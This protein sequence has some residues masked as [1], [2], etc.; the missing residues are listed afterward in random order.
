LPPV[1]FGALQKLFKWLA[2]FRF[3]RGVFWGAAPPKNCLKDPAELI[4]PVN[5]DSNMWRR[6]LYAA[7]ASDM[8]RRIQYA[9][10]AYGMR[11]PHPVC[12][13]AYGMR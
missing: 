2:A 1:R 9:V 8:R 11:C 12:G 10:T 5:S 6:I 13:T 4:D 7:A 3:H